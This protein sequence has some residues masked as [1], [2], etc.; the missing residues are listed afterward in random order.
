GVWVLQISPWRLPGTLLAARGV[1]LD[2]LKKGR[3]T[4]PQDNLS[5]AITGQQVILSDQGTAALH[6]GHEHSITHQVPI[7]VIDLLKVIDIQQEERTG[8]RRDGVPLDEL[9]HMRIKGKTIVGACEA[10]CERGLLRLFYVDTQRF[11]FL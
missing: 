2:P 4:H 9:L 7:L 10:V 8:E 3:P 1:F 11:H 5:P 6:Q